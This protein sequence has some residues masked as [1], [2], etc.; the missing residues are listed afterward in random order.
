MLVTTV[1]VL[2]VAAVAPC[3]HH[4]NEASARI[5]DSLC[6]AFLLFSCLFLM[7]YNIFRDE[8]AIKYPAHGHALWNP[9]HEGLDSVVQ[10]G[11]V[12]FT[13][14]GKFI[15]LFNVLLPRDHPSHQNFGVPEYHEPLKLKMPRHIYPSK[16]GPNI[17]CSKGVQPD[18]DVLSA[19]E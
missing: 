5:F 15:R 7:E 11:D 4:A 13:Q 2:V 8:L 1:L 6:A 9:S 17:F 18:R 16:L 14:Y 3:A 12:G 19:V 10:V